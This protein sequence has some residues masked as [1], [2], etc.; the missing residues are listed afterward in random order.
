MDLT[1]AVVI[2]PGW[3]ILFYGWQSSGE[4]VSLGETCDAMF[5]LSGAIGWVGKQAQLSAKPVSLGEGWQLIA[6]AITEGHIKPRGPGHPHSIPLHQHHSI[7]VIKTH[8]HKQQ[9]SWWL[10]NDGRLPDFALGQYIMSEVGDHSETGT[11]AID[12]GSY[13]WPYHGHLPSHQIMDSKVTEVWCQHP[14]QWHQ[15][16]RGSGGSRH[17]HDG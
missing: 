4:G 5:T 13:G 3:A 12:N 9:T 8:L 16:Q 17:S 14:L 2:G 6:Q 11:E 7:S 15:C 1:E 10:Q